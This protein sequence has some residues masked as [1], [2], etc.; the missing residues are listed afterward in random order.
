LVAMKPTIAAKPSFVVESNGIHH[1]RVSIPV[2]GRIAEVR[3]IEIVTV[4][5]ALRRNDPPPVPVL[6][7]RVEKNGGTGTHYD[8]MRSA[9]PWNSIGVAFQLRI[10]F[11]R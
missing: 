6:A 11:I 4:L 2:R 8:P 5:A 7:V 9:F 1:E 10:N 3:R